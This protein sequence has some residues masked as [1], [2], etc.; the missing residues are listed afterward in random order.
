M[1]SVRFCCI[2]SPLPGMRGYCFLLEKCNRHSAR[3]PSHCLT[4]CLGHWPTF[5][6]NT[7]VNSGTSY[8]FKI[9]VTDGGRLELKLSFTI[10]GRGQ[11]ASFTCREEA[12]GFV[13][14]K[15]VTPSP[16][17]ALIHVLSGDVH[18]DA[19]RLCL[20]WQHL[21]HYNLTCGKRKWV[22]LQLNIELMKEVGRGGLTLISLRLGSVESNFCV[23][24]VLL[25]GKSYLASAELTIL[26]NGKWQQSENVL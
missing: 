16:W 18:E 21:M 14:M 6:S 23:W 4:L 9:Y 26:A 24:M 17:H 2:V 19:L 7:L 22:N 11:P 8:V 25:W 12:F 5:H 20:S 10:L 15:C 1:T 3:R 13:S